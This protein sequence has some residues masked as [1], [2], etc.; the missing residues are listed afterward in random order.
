[1][2]SDSKRRNIR[3]FTITILSDEENEKNSFHRLMFTMSKEMRGAKKHKV[4]T[5]KFTQRD[6]QAKIGVDGIIL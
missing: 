2:R 1:M 4:I 6:L 5:I 3:I